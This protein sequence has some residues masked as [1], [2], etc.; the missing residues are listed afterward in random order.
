MNAPIQ[1]RDPQLWRM[2]RRRA[3]FKSHLVTYVFVN[4]LLWA[5]WYFTG[6]YTHGFVPW[7]VWPSVFWGLGLA[8]Q[9]LTTYGFLNEQSWSEREY[10]QLLRDKE[11]GRL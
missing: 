10:Q 6:A 8:I 1:D 4:A 3:A 5:I 7:P 9:G 11:A 2:A